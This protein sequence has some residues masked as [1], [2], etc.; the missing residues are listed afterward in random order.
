MKT[1][2]ELPE[3]RDLISTSITDEPSVNLNDGGIIRDGYNSELDELRGI[4]KNAKQTIASFE[5]AERERTGI[6]SLRVKFN[7]VFGYFIEISKANL[8]R[9]PEDYERRQTLTNSSGL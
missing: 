6:T 1:F 3:L 8:S 2:F 4:S 7:N 9:A 5:S